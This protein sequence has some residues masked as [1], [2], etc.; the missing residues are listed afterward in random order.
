MSTYSHLLSEANTVTV[1]LPSQTCFMDSML[2]QTHP[3]ITTR[4]AKDVSETHPKSGLLKNLFFFAAAMVHRHTAHR[5]RGTSAFVF[6]KPPAH[7][8]CL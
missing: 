6:S 7:A 4:E 8:N 3:D 1:L 5:T 2:E